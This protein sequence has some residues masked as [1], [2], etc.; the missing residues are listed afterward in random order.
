MSFPNAT[1]DGTFLI[2]T[3]TPTQVPVTGMLSFARKLPASQTTLGV[4]EECRREG[5]QESQLSP[6]KSFLTPRH[7]LQQP[8]YVLYLVLVLSD[9]QDL[10]DMGMGWAKPQEGHTPLCLREAIN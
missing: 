1:W 9:T 4:K 7:L 10:T 2:S 5:E 8:C 6:R 3:L